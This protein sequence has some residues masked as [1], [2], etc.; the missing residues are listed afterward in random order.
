MAKLFG[1]FGKSKF[2]LFFFCVF[3]VIAR[4]AGQCDPTGPRKDCGVSD[5]TV[6]LNEHRSSIIATA[7]QCLKGDSSC[8]PEEAFGLVLQISSAQ[9]AREVQEK[10]R[11]RLLY[12]IYGGVMLIT[13]FVVFVASF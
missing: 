9:S 12:L 11:S 1:S 8:G 7:N 13:L 4:A 3:S 10:D 6:V 5:L 2:C